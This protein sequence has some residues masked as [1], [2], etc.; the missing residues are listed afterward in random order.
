MDTMPRSFAGRLLAALP[1]LLLGLW[2]FGSLAAPAAAQEDPPGRVGRVAELSGN[3]YRFDAAS[4]QWLAAD[5]NR[6]LTGGDRLSTA[7][8]GRAQVQVGSSTLRLGH[9]TELEVLRLDDQ[10]MVFQLHAGTLAVR[11]RSREVARELE[12]DTAEA[13]L[14][15]ER[16]GYYRIDRSNDDT[17]AG[18]WSG[19]LRVADLPGGLVV[20]GQR[21]QLYRDGNALRM[22]SGVMIADAFSDWA[23]RADR[24]DDQRGAAY[25]Y[26]SPEMT[27]ADDLDRYGSWT[28]SDDYGPIWYPTTVVVGWT[29]YR[30]G[31]WAWVGPWG[32][33]WVDD[34]PWGFAPFHYGRWVWWGGR[35]GWCPGAYVAQPVFAP[36][37]VAW[38]G[39][40]HWSV[41]INV[42]GGPVV[43]WVPLAPH[44]VYLPWYR[45]TPRYQDRLYTPWPRGG[46]VPYPRQVP[47]GPIMYTNQG[48]PGGVTVVPRDVL[49]NR[50]QVARAVVRVP[51]AT[52]RPVQTGFV[53]APPPHRTFTPIEALDRARMP[54]RDRVPPPPGMPPRGATPVPPVQAVP[55]GAVPLPPRHGPGP[56]PQGQAVPMPPP[57][58]GRPVMPAPQTEVRPVPAPPAVTTT[59][60]AATTTPAPHM[61]P[62]PVPAVQPAPQALPERRPPEAERSREPHAQ[63]EQRRERPV[64]AERIA[65]P[66]SERVTAP[67]PERAAAPPQERGAPARERVA[68]APAVVAPPPRTFEPPP[69][70][71][72]EERRRIPEP[73]SRERM[74]EREAAR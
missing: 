12:V 31:H 21:V 24:R 43:G 19:E 42:G 15:P 39:G 46:S 55:G 32:W 30:Y 54:E 34:A 10:R 40:A 72:D 5:R 49:V 9:A 4:G 29:P 45:H 48:V 14:L 70:R 73:V 63:S 23:Q 3:V 27:G 44:E 25:A 6:P 11:V 7:V 53:P 26:V 59:P 18:A 52:R 64:P 74:R 62:L 67:P 36:A 60:P 22:A 69:E 71:R 57:T 1:G 56:A 41:G 58:H 38:V 2:L 51:D 13:R 65:A 68:P 20:P 47:T 61:R 66:P 33:T 50:E 37:L 35:W 17:W 28:Q 16:S 8:D